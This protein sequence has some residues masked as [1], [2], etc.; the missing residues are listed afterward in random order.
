MK[1]LS[2][3]TICQSIYRHCLL[4]YYLLVARNCFLILWDISTFL[5]YRNKGEDNSNFRPFKTTILS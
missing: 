2:S 3:R 1:I 4:K 5:V